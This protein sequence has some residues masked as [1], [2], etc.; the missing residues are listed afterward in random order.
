[1][2]KRIRISDCSVNSYGYRVLTGGIDLGQYQVNPVL[3][4]MHE[5]GCII[6]V[7][8]DLKV[9]GEELTGE[10]VFDECSELSKTCKK[11]Y[12]FGSLK[13]CSVG[14]DVK[15]V[16]DDA[17]LLVKGQTRPT[18]TK[19]QLMEVSLVDIG[20][21]RNSVVLMKEGKEIELSEGGD[22]CLPLLNIKSKDKVQKKM[23]EKE[24][25]LQLGLPAT[26]TTAEIQ[27]KLSTLGKAETE[28]NTLKE[29]MTAL[30]KKQVEELVNRAV[31]DKKI[32]EEKKQQ[33][34]DLGAK[35]GA[36]E[37]A[38]VL[39]AMNPR[40]KLAEVVGHQG[41]AAPADDTW[42]TLKDVP[43]D[44]I[45]E[46]KEKDPNRYATLYKAAYGIDLK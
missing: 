44:K 20:S 34:L 28:L 18:V 42:K 33:F 6:G 26:A 38:N 22:C 9:E 40:V 13:M 29:Q 45:L 30:Q 14:L 3:L 23:E 11:Q 16:S 19:C 24:L 32:G 37:L 4:Y 27:A 2:A 12:D 46:L 8:K 10:P 25:A 15:E 21:N 31:S 41:G 7:M 5:R 35:V 39:G 17:S 36:T 1:M 43:A